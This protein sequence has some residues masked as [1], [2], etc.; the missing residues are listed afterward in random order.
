MTHKT[1]AFSFNFTTREQ[2]M[3]ERAAWKANYKAMSVA[4][5]DAKMALKKA[6]RDEDFRAVDR[7]MREVNSNKDT[8]RTLLN[9]LAS[10]KVEAQLQYLTATGH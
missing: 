3:T 10:A 2:Y 4:Q 5:R 6:F 8:A 1:F 7:L 9:G